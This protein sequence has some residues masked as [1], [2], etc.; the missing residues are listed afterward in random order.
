M[1]DDPNLFLD[2]HDRDSE[3]RAKIRE[4]D[5]MDMLGSALSA[6]AN[7]IDVE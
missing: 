6:R 5:P 7:T 4:P 3:D 2:Q 1:I